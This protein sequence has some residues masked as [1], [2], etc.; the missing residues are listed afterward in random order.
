MAKKKANK[1]SAKTTG[2]PVKKRVSEH[3]ERLKTSNVKYLQVKI[4]AECVRKLDRLCSQRDVGRSE[5]IESLI[6]SA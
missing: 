3:R 1:K 4:P 5:L 6:K 2:T